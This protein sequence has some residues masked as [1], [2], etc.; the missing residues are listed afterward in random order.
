ML[1][2]MSAY[3]SQLFSMAACVIYC[4]IASAAIVLLASAAAIWPMRISWKILE[5]NAL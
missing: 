4:P 2:I 3:A 1:R 5:G